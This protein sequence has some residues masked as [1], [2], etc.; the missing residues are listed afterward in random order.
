MSG[1]DV[2]LLNEGV[3]SVVGFTGRTGGDDPSHPDLHLGSFRF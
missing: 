3:E 1:S 2:D